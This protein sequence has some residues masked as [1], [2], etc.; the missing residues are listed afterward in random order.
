VGIAVQVWMPFFNYCRALTIL[1]KFGDNG[2][3]GH[4]MVSV[5]VTGTIGVFLGPYLHAVLPGVGENA[6]I[7]HSPL[8]CLSRLRQVVASGTSPRR[9]GAC[10]P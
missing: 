8:L 2:A 7:P 4:P 5:F 6:G 1:L 10:Q 9:D 3:Y